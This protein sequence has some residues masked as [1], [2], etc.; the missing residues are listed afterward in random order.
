MSSHSSDHV[1]VRPHVN[2]VHHH[3]HYLHLREFLIIAIGVAVCA[4]ILGV[5]IWAYLK[6]P[7]SEHNWAVKDL[8]Q[9][10]EDPE[11]TQ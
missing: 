2:S 8:S 4:G 11:S 5:T 10:D 1:H 3:P 9:E 7:P 6:E